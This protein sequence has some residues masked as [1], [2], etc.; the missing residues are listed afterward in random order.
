M[1]MEV[2]I[3]GQASDYADCTDWRESRTIR[4]Q[5]EARAWYGTAKI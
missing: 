2:T 5:V 3:G 4:T 1:G